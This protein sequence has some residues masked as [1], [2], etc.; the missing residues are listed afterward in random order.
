MKE[1]KILV[2][3][4]GGLVTAV[5]SNNPNVKI[6]VVDYDSEDWAENGE[7]GL[8]VEGSACIGVQKPDQVVDN[9]SELFKEDDSQSVYVKEQL[10]KMKF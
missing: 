3:L 2:E 8:T 6:V 9:L 7:P 4:K 10:T 5:C 1:T